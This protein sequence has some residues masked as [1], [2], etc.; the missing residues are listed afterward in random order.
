[1]G[2]PLN[3]RIAQVGEAKIHGFRRLISPRVGGS[4]SHPSGFVG[5]PHYS[6]LDLDLDFLN[7]GA[8]DP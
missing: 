1:M 7:P 5:H 4:L 6:E 3:D 8:E 2:S